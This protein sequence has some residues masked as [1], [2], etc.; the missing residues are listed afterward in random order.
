MIMKNY[1]LKHLVSFV[2]LITLGFSATAQ[3]C[4]VN[5]GLNQTGVRILNFSSQVHHPG[6]WYR[7]LPG[8]K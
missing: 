7:N 8:L 3:N 4:W 2:F 1:L 6:W 5:A